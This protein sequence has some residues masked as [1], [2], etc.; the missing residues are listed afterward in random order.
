MPDKLTVKRRSDQI[1]DTKPGNLPEYIAWR[2][3][4]PF[5]VSP[6]N[7][8]DNLLL[9][10][11]A[12]TNFE[13]IVDRDS[14]G[15]TVAE[16]CERYF[17][18]HTE[19]EVLSHST[20]Y[21]LAPLLLV[22][23]AASERFR[24]IRICHYVNEVDTEA[25]KQMAAV[26]YLLPDGT[27]YVAFRGTDSTIVGWKEDCQ[28]A[29]LEETAGQKRAVDYLN[30]FALPMLE[31]A[32]SQAG[33]G[34]AAG[35]ERL[36]IGGH[37]K[38]GNFAVYAGAFCDPAVKPYILAIYSND[39]P[40]F[41]K[42]VTDTVEYRRILPKIISIIP[43]CSII[44][45]ILTNDYKETVVRSDEHLIMQHDAMS[46]QILGGRFVE[47][48]ETSGI[49]RWADKTIEEWLTGLDLAERKAFF[50]TLFALFEVGDI[51]NL[52]D[53]RANKIATMKALYQAMSDLPPETRKK[54]D[55]MIQ[56]LLA[57]GG[58]VWR[59]AALANLQALVDRDKGSRTEDTDES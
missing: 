58:S 59:A 21:K 25:D 11:L 30:E 45:T 54:F 40:G 16:V 47:A 38:G 53:M 26:S 3:D 29:F 10:Q 49:S 32:A 24:D 37:S 56:K 13:D 42:S 18:L 51:A 43:E 48:D 50:D 52:E 44:G 1:A 57:A 55:E 22:P 7:E 41:L 12:Y 15:L 33:A 34:G 2:G 23:M 20:F 27:V 14:P 4:L 19:D 9:A 8:V 31:A 36:R 46:W 5:S 35:E 6:F 17:E 39:G 28:L